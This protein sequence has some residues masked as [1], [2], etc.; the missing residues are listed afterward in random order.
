MTKYTSHTPVNATLNILFSFLKLNVCKPFYCTSCSFIL[1]PAILTHGLFSVLKLTICKANTLDYWCIAV[2]R[3]TLLNFSKYFS[4][5]SME[6]LRRAVD[7]ASAREHNHFS[8]SRR[9]N[10]QCN[11]AE[12]RT[13]RTG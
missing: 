3:Q 11:R 8:A 12:I 5:R 6:N 4:E 13:V 7:I 10:Q 9:G 2:F 1:M